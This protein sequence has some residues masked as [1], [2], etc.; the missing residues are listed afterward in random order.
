MI[1]LNRGTLYMHF[2]STNKYVDKNLIN[3]GNHFPGLSY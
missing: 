1:K 2:G 3:L